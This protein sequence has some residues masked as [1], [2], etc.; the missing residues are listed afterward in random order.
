MRC[1]NLKKQMK[2]HERKNGNED[3]VVNREVKISY[4]YEKFTALENKVLADSEVFNRK[5]ELRQN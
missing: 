5:I 2:R 1:D 4:T 3:N